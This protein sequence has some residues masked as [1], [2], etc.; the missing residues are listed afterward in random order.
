MKKKI[1]SIA[2]I[3]VILMI[4]IP[5][6][7]SDNVENA[8]LEKVLREVEKTNA[9]IKAEVEFAQRLCDMPGM[10][11]EDIDKV[12]DTLVMVT[13]YQAKST[14][15]M[16]EAQGVTVECQYDLYIIGGR[17]VLIDPLVVPHW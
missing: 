9:L 10:T 1:V 8:N 2:L 7:A 14:I 12:I 11:E 5:A 17:E 3:L 4:S 15:K 6:F 13:N 16:A